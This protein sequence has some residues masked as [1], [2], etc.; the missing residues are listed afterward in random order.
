MSNMDQKLPT[1]IIIFVKILHQ[2]LPRI[3]IFCNYFR[4]ILHQSVPLVSLSRGFRFRF[5]GYNVTFTNISDTSWRSVLLMAETGEAGENHRLAVSHWQTL[6]HNVISSTPH[7]SGIW[8]FVLIDTDYIGS[9]K[10]NYHTITTHT[11]N[12]IRNFFK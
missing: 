10:S 6:S 1:G 9:C 12:T 4:K 3:Y 11:N 8:T 2:S 7:M 5:M